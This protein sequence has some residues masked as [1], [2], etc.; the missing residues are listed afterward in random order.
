MINKFL[1]KARN[2]EPASRKRDL[3]ILKSREKKKVSAE[4][5]GKVSA[6]T[7]ALPLVVR[8]I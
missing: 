6:G 7:V 5:A 8:L 2:L 1:Y 3:E 4:N